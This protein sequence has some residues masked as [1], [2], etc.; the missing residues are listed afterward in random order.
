MSAFDINKVIGAVLGSLLMLWAISMIVDGIYPMPGAEH[1]EDAERT[2]HYAV[3][4]PEGEATSAEAA[5]GEAATGEAEGAAVS[6]GALLA[7][8]DQANGEKVAKKCSACHT[9]EAGGAN[10]VGP[11][12]H[13]IVGA[14]RAQAAEFAYSAAIAELGGTWTYEELDAYLASPKTYAPGTK[15]TFAGVKSAEDRA[16]LLLFLASVTDAPPPLPAP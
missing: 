14:A 1:G 3:N 11:N 15:M 9:F 4:L 10:K 2:L 8:A 12:L 6:L 13:N 5:S 7:A 16:D